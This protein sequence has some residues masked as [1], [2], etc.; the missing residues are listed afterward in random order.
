MVAGGL[1]L[2]FFFMASCVILGWWSERGGTALR[3]FSLGQDSIVALGGQ[4][5]ISLYFFF[6]YFGFNTLNR[7]DQHL[8]IVALSSGKR[9]AEE[10]VCACICGI[11]THT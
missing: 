8:F 2:F 6:V 1:R 7:L 10:C 5:A 4:Y 11:H 3:C 9:T